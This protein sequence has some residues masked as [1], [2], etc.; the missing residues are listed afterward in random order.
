MGGV[1][2]VDLIVKL[3]AI[4]ILLAMTSNQTHVLPGTGIGYGSSSFIHYCRSGAT[5]VWSV[6]LPFVLVDPYG[7]R[8]DCVLLPVMSWFVHDDL[9]G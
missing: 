2:L 4:F 7:Y 9:F 3:T 5:R 8:F 6:S 1:M